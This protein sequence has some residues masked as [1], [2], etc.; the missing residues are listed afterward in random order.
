QQRDGLWQPCR[1]W[2]RRY[3]RSHCNAHRHELHRVRQLSL[4]RRWHL[5]RWLTHILGSVDTY[6]STYNLIGIT[7]VEGLEDGV[8]GNIVGVADPKLLPLGYYGGAANTN[9][10]CP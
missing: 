6:F 4:Q 9:T 1:L 3:L 7:D 2:R 5:L 10:S 8:Y